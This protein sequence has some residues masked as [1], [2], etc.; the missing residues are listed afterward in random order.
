MSGNQALPPVASSESPEWVVDSKHT[1]EGVH[2]RSSELVSKQKRQPFFTIAASWQLPLQHVS[3][4]FIITGV[5][6]RLNSAILPSLAAWVSSTVSTSQRTVEAYQSFRRT[7]HR[8]TCQSN[9]ERSVPVGVDH[10][11]LEPIVVRIATR[12]PP[13][14][15]EQSVLQRMFDWV[16]GSDSVSGV[17]FRAPRIAFNGDFEDSGALL[18]RC[19]SEYMSWVLSRTMARHLFM[20]APALSLL[21]RVTARIVL[22]RRVLSVKSMNSETNLAIQGP[23]QRGLASAIALPTGQDRVSSQ[24]NQRNLLGAILQNGPGVITRLAQIEAGQ[25][26]PAPAVASDQTIEIV[27]ITDTLESSRLDAAAEGRPLFLQVRATDKWMPKDER[28]E[29][30]APYSERIALMLTSAY[31]LFVDRKTNELVN[32][33]IRRDSIASYRVLGKR[34]QIHCIFVREMPVATNA[35]RLSSRDTSSLASTVNEPSR[36]REM[37]VHEII[38]ETPQYALWLQGR[39]PLPNLSL[40]ML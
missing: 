38:C 15:L 35:A 6:L 33:R 19:R 4:H 13:R 37:S 10:I 32:P 24:H 1:T 8:Q 39:L 34:L 30:F 14:P 28:F 31:V 23:S 27:D 17:L 29:F 36:Q 21:A 25:Q 11:V 26:S 22:R 18:R 2:E 9:G 40:L 16:L 12:A 3:A 7:T 20:Q 5:D